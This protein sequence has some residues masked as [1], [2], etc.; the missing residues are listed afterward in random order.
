MKKYQVSKYFKGNKRITKLQGVAFMFAGFVIFVFVISALFLF[1]VNLGH[2]GKAL[3]G[4]SDAS[5]IE[6]QIR[7]Y[8]V[9]E[10]TKYLGPFFQSTV[11]KES[12]TIYYC[13]CYDPQTGKR[14]E[15]QYRISKK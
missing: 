1:L 6:K 13:R 4:G 2:V 9:S 14:I 11:T 10:C 8:C 7:G 12:E 5:S 15:R 3:K